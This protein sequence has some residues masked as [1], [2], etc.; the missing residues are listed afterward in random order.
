VADYQIETS[1]DGS[2]GSWTTVKTGT[3]TAGQNGTLVPLTVS[4]AGVEYV[5][6]TILSNQTPAPYTTTCAGGGGPSGCHYTDLS[7]LEV[8]GTPSP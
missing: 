8:F 2:N 7:E 1:P 3:F 6:F 5:R 4:Q